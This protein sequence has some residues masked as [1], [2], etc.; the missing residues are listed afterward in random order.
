[1]PS[2]GQIH[3][4]HCVNNVIEKSKW[5]VKYKK[6]KDTY[7]YIYAYFTHKDI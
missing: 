1:M 3:L 6:L 2:Y 5:R 4:C 7:I